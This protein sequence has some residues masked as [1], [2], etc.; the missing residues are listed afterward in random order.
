MKQVEGN[1]A[2]TFNEGQRLVS[3]LELLYFG[4][5]SLHQQVCVHIDVR[6]CEAQVLTF[7]ISVQKETEVSAL[8]K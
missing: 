6:M 5:I 2:V 4:D 7:V 8:Q 1:V 3:V